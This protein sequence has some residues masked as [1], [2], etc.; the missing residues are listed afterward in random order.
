MM[1]L[2]KLH[3]GILFSAP[4]CGERNF[5]ADRDGSQYSYYSRCGDVGHLHISLSQLV[6]TYIVA[7]ECFFVFS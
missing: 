3:Q 6:S 4:D 7:N 5:T 2:V 1:D